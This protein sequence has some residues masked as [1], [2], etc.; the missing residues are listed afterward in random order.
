MTEEGKGRRREGT[1][2]ILVIEDEDRFRAIVE[3]MLAGTGIAARAVPS[4]EAGL[5]AAAQRPPEIVIT[6]LRLPGID[7][8]GVLRLLRSAPRP[9]EVILMSAHADVTV[10]VQGFRHGACDILQKPFTV[11]RLLEAIEVAEARRAARPGERQD[12]PASAGGGDDGRTD[13]AGGEPPSLIGVSPAMQAI[14]ALIA[15]VAPTAATVLVEGETGTGKE[16][17][18]RT[19]HERSR[20]RAGPFVPVNCGAIAEPLLEAE[21]FGH[22]AGAFTGATARRAGFVRASSQGTLFLDEVGELTPS[23]QVKLLRVLQ[24]RVVVPVGASAGVEVDVRVVAAT[25]R[26]LDAAVRAGEFR[27]D[28]FY[29]LNVVRIRIPPLRERREDVPVLAHHLLGRIARRYGRSVEGIEPEALS[30]LASHAF[31]GNVRELENIIERSVALGAPGRL[32]LAD[33]PPEIVGHEP[34]PAAGGAAGAAAPTPA[35]DSPGSA[36]DAGPP[37]A[38]ALEVVERQLYARAL[39]SAGGNRERAARLLGVCSRTVTR[40]VKRYGL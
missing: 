16:V 36:P 40:K 21:L 15:R 33:L 28:L 3:R 26:D 6:D 4:G 22:E 30:A 25:N 12:R 17:V 18:A 35:A 14:D 34:T 20:R 31:P 2:D 10:A 24:E 19:I 11:A 27:Q 32:G 13:A 39:A 38:S 5:A 8:L 9:P 29:R 37:A 23:A 1:R 7:G